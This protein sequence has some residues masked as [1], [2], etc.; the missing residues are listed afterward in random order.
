[1]FYVR[2]SKTIFLVYDCWLKLQQ[3]KDAL[4]NTINPMSIIRLL[5]FTILHLNFLL[6]EG[7]TVILLKKPGRGTILTIF[8]KNFLWLLVEFRRLLPETPYFYFFVHK[9]L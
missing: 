7:R 9:I 8:N 6:V 3:I 5:N 2:T 4:V 1:M